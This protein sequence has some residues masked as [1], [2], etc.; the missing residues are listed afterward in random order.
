LYKKGGLKLVFKNE[1]SFEDALVNLLISQKGWDEV[2]DN[3]SEEDLIQ[4]WAD[5][6]FQNNKEKDRLKMQ[7]KCR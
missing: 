4:N 1:Q 3:P 6:L 5:I 2:L 7:A